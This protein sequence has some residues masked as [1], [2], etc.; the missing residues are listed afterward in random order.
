MRDADRPE[1][2]GAED[3]SEAGL[4]QV[5][6]NVRVPAKTR[7]HLLLEDRGLTD[8]LGDHR[9]QRRDRRGVGVHDSGAGGQLLAAQ[10]R[11]DLLGAESE[12]ALAPGLP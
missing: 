5:D 4:A 9:D 12:V 3:H 2:P 1:H 10:R 7:V 11:H 8:H 6:L